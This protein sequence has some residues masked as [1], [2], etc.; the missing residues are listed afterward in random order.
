MGGDPHLTA[1][2]NWGWTF[3]PSFQ[4]HQVSFISFTLPTMSALMGVEAVAC[5]GQGNLFVL[6]C[7]EALCFPGFMLSML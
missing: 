5:C 2:A 1:Y 3:M 4:M 7:M 6:I